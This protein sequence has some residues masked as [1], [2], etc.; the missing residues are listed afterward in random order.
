MTADVFTDP[1][2]TREQWVDVRMTDPEEGEWDIDVVVAEGRV[3]YVDL[4]IKPDLLSAFVECL[5][6]D[7][8]RDRASAI[9]AAIA[10]R[11]ELDLSVDVTES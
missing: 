1:D 4:R 10:E 3:E 7:L 9:L 2:E 6:D 11:N 8:G 5:I